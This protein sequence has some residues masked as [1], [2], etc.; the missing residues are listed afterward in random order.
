MMTATRARR[1]SKFYRIRLLNSA[2]DQ[3]FRSDPI[4]GNSFQV[5]TGLIEPGLTFIRLEAMDLDD[6]VLQNRS[7]TFTQF[8]AT[9]VPEPSTTTLIGGGLAILLGFRRHRTP[10]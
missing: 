9:A 5:P 7:S 2:S 8:F 10:F 6:G 1:T 3:F 4:F